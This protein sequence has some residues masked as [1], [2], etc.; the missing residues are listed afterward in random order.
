MDFFAV[1]TLDCSVHHH[2]TLQSANRRI[3]LLRH[4]VTS[5]NIRALLLLTTS[6]VR[7]LTDKVPHE[8]WSISQS[9]VW[10][11]DVLCDGSVS[12]MPINPLNISLELLAIGTLLFTLASGAIPYRS[13]PPLL[14]GTDPSGTDWLGT[15]IHLF[16]LE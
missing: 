4:C 15:V 9:S 1:S 5:R 11:E 3:A 7:L 16:T 10:L 14:R 12:L 13:G 2:R 6:S 8:S